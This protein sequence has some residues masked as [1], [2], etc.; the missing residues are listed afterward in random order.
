MEV[1]RGQTPGGP[2]GEPVPTDRTAGAMAMGF[3]H[4]S[5]HAVGDSER[6]TF[7]RGIEEIEAWGRAL[8]VHGSLTGQARRE[9]NA[10]YASDLKERRENAKAWLRDK[11]CIAAELPYE[12]CH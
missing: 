4:E 11:F 7:A 2:A 3:G 9:A 6:G 5:V 8:D 10:A 1:G 12:A